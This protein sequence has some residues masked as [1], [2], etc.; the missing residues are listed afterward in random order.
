MQTI[1]INKKFKVRET[2]KSINL[3]IAGYDCWIPKK[4]ISSTN[5]SNFKIEVNDNFE[6]KLQKYSPQINLIKNAIEV[7]ELIA[8]YKEISKQQKRN[9]EEELDNLQNEE[10]INYFQNFDLLGL[11]L[12]NKTQE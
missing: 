9:L 3:R 10:F 12:E 5:N 4:F 7:Q 6:F 8:E 1:I 11:G 2:E